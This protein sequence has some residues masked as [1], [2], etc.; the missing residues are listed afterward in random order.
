M[1]H[2]NIIFQFEPRFAADSQIEL[3]IAAAV[4]QYYKGYYLLL[5]SL[6]KWTETRLFISI[7][8]RN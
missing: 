6:F 8:W 7:H 2:V 5:D 1:L 4:L 3:I